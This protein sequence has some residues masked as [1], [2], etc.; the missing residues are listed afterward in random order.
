MTYIVILLLVFFVCLG[1]I[2]LGSLWYMRVLLEKMIGSKL[3]DLESLTATGSIPEAWSVKYDRQMIHYQMLGNTNQVKRIQQSARKVYLN[4]IGKLLA[5]VRR[6]TLVESEEAR[7]HTLRI[8][9]RVEREW[10]DEKTHG[11]F[12]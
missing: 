5:Y 10:R 4:K 8:L 7:N 2:M 11:S 3:H 12:S 1:L 9:Q 6:T